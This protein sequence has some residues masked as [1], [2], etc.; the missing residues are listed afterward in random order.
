MPTRYKNKDIVINRSEYYAPLRK[1]RGLSRLR[2]YATT[3][4]R[5]PTM[6]QRVRVKT[7]DHRWSY[8]DR[9]YNIAHTFYGDARYWWVVAWWNGYG[10]EAD[11]AIGAVITVPLNIEDALKALGF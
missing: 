10:L 2:Q 9:L 1:S 7:V 8:G 6:A 3:P 11:I 5:N 4:M